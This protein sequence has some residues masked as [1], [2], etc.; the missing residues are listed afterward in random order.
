MKA[1][2]HLVRHGLSKAN[3]DLLVNR[4]MPDHAIELADE[5]HRQAREAGTAL[6]EHIMG[7][8]PDSVDGFHHRRVRLLVSPYTRTRQTAD[9]IA[10]SLEKNGVVFDRREEL[11]LREQSFGLF[12]GIPDDELPVK[13]PDHHEH[14]AKHTRFEGEFFAPM[15]MGESRAMVTDRVRGCFGTILRDITGKY[16]P[17]ITDMIIVSHGVTIRCLL[18]AWLHKP[19]EWCEK[20]PNPWNCSITTIEGEQGRGWTTTK[21]FAGFEHKKVTRQ[22][23]R[24]EGHVVPEATAEGE[25]GAIA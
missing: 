2:I 11:L 22:E 20:E 7:I 21:T 14:Y 3:L 16:S 10:E 24:E 13:Y 15:P 18:T 5:G 9:G 25:A 12:D 19:W 1:R 6:A 17:P 8:G 23:R 4:R